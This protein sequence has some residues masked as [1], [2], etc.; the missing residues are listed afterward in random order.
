MGSSTFFTAITAICWILCCIFAFPFFPLFPC[1]LLLL[2][3][4][5]V[6][7]SLSMFFGFVSIVETC[8]FGYSTPFS[9]VLDSDLI[10]AFSVSTS[11]RWKMLFCVGGVDGFEHLEILRLVIRVCETLDVCHFFCTLFA[12]ITALNGPLERTIPFIWPIFYFGSFT[13]IVIF[14]FGLL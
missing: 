13:C 12:F 1:I 14:H 6:G 5:F 8:V 9:L 2:Y 3:L 11:F 7:F 4:G 10:N